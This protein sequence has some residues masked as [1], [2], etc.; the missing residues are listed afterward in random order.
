MLLGI[1]IVHH[2]W[3][4]TLVNC[5][6]HWGLSSKPFPVFVEQVLRRVGVFE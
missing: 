2:I 6:L 4:A 3:S 5:M 1:K